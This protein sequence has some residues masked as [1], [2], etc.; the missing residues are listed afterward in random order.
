MNF[1]AQGN[2]ALLILAHQD[3][4]MLRRIVNRVSPLG[5]TYVHIDAKTN[6]SKWQCDDL[7]CIF[8]EDRI[9]VFWGHWSEVEGTVLLLEKAL[10]DPSNMRFTLLS[11]THYP[12]LS[13][14]TLEL[15]AM[16]SGN[17][18]GSR[19]APNMPDG[20]RP[21]VDYQR[22]FYRT[23]RPNGLWSRIKNGVMNRVIFY[24][25]PLDWRSVTPA[26]GMRAGEQFWSLNREFAEYCV[27]RI[28]S[29]SP[30]IEYFKLI[31]CSDEKVFAT[32]YGEFAGEISLEGTT[33]T[34]WMEK[35]RLNGQY[36]APISRADIEEAIEMDKFW[37]A[38]KLGSSDSR[39]LDWLDGF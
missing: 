14:Q 29:S 8:I 39:I 23:L 36:P 24:R 1:A 4:Q 16:A 12:I 27:E 34:R 25:R 3:E 5:P 19:P 6:I 28:R 38:R 9:R 20:S 18:I 32:L 33:F 30:L 15:R 21:E 35:P 22:R 2:H 37:F 11:G 17:V 13:N 7:P 31:V 26:S 10:A